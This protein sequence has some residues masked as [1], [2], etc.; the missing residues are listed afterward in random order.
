M[1]FHSVPDGNTIVG[2]AYLAVTGTDQPTIT[3]T[4]ILARRSGQRRITGWCSRNIGL[5]VMHA[6]SLRIKHQIPEAVL[7]DEDSDAR[8]MALLCARALAVITGSPLAEASGPVAR[9]SQDQQALDE[10]RSLFPEFADTVASEEPQ[11]AS[12]SRHPLSL[13]PELVD[14]GLEVGLLTRS[15]TG[16]HATESM[17]TIETGG[18]TCALAANVRLQAAMRQVGQVSVWP[19]AQLDLTAAQRALASASQL[20]PSTV[21]YY[22][23]CHNPA[24]TDRQ[25]AA[26]AYPLLAARLAETP[27]LAAAIDARAPLGPMITEVTGLTSAKLKRLARIHLTNESVNGDGDPDDPMGPEGS[28]G[29]DLAKLLAICRRLDSSWVPDTAPNWCLLSDLHGSLIEPLAVRYEQDSLSFLLPAKGQWPTYVGKLA[30][31]IDVEREHFDSRAMQIVSGEIVSLV[32]DFLF[33]VLLPSHLLPIMRRGDPLPYPGPEI[34]LEA[35]RAG[36]EMLAGT[37]SDPIG[38]LV[39][40]QTRWQNRIPSLYALEQQSQH[41]R[42]IHDQKRIRTCTHWPALAG[43]FTTSAGYIIR[44]LNS[45]RALKEESRRLNHCVGSLYV[46]PARHGIA[47]LFSIQSDGGDCSHSTFEVSRPHSNIPDQAIQDIAVVQHKAKANRKPGAKLRTA[48]EEW[49]TA[50]RSG[51]IDLNLDAV[52]D[53]HEKARAARS[54]HSDPEGVR[55]SPRMAWNRILSTSWSDQDINALI[56]EEWYRHILPRQFPSPDTLLADKRILALGN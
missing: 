51:T 55:I 25:Q 32:D 6:T 21:W 13:T 53:W 11:G 16:V 40:L 42:A 50:V 35:G 31:R 29:A 10:F 37:A 1:E 41:I 33:S 30:K 22:G 36:F 28:R 38:T 46:T 17:L 14:L 5:P 34:L 19:P 47:H 43:D 26:A 48:L 27:E 15:A 54:V 8:L 3:D 24:R 23:D 39:R 52:M 56:R 49:L 4:V 12:P 7:D 20:K 9:D 2:F 45:V 18:D 44:C